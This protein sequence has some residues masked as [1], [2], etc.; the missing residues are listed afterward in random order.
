MTLPKEPLSRQEQYLNKIATGEGELPIQ[1]LSRVEQ[2][3]SYICENGGAGGGS[4]NSTGQDFGVLSAYP[5]IQHTS[6]E[7]CEKYIILDNM[8]SYSGI[9]AFYYNNILETM[10]LA[11][12]TN[13]ASFKAGKSYIATKCGGSY[14]GYY[15]P[16][17]A[18]SAGDSALTYS[19]NLTRIFTNDEEAYNI[20]INNLYFKKANIMLEKEVQFTEVSQLRGS[21][22]AINSY[23]GKQGQLIVNTDDYSLH[24][25]DGIT[26]GGHKISTTSALSQANITD[27][28][29]RILMLENIISAMQV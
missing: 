10:E 22:E 29:E 26:A 15:I 20:F 3:L 17:P 21:T 5:N 12:D 19:S 16:K 27:L 18:K 1:P 11:S 9:M 24:V 7:G 4:S 28:E 8:G 6:F 23:V 2:Y 13:R 14:P 25:M